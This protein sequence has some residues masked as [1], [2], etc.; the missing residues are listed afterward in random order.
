M[1]I[2]IDGNRY[3]F[4]HSA[5]GDDAETIIEIDNLEDRS[6]NAQIRLTDRSQTDPAGRFRYRIVG[7]TVL[8]ER[9][10]LANWADYK[11]LLTLNSDGAVIEFTEAGLSSLLE[12]LQLELETGGPLAVQVAQLV[13]T[14]IL[15]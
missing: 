2:S 7:D 3:R 8:F 4:T 11:T 12:R 1:G 15:T 13:Q 5:E 10:T 14:A 9:A 6:L